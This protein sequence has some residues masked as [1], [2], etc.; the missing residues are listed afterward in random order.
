MKQALGITGAGVSK[1]KQHPHISGLELAIEVYQLAQVLGMDGVD[2]VAPA[3][4]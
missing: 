2:A 4:P 3:Q 1:G